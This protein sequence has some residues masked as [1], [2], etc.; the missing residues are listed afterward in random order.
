MLIRLSFSA[1]NAIIKSDNEFLLKPGKY[2]RITVEDHG[3]GIPKKHL[4]KIFDPYFTTKTK[5]S[6]LGLSICYSIIKK[7]KG[8][9]NVESKLG[10]GTK[11]I[12]Y[13]PASL[14]KEKLKKREKKQ[15]TKI[16]KGKILVMDDELT[17]RKSSVRLLT[18]NGFKVTCATEGNQAIKLFKTARD[19]KEPFD[20]VIMDLT[21][22]GG[23]GGKEAAKRILKIDSK[24]KIIVSSGYSD[25]PVMAHYKKYG[26]SGA[27]AKPYSMEEL[28]ASI[29]SVL[30]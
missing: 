25:N 27:L 29:N 7:H 18:Q 19:L 5:G 11:F 22:P 23:M 2:I 21:V 17:V 15:W 3:K 30:G 4:L 9:I 24:A 8:S 28:N 16:N 26:F 1:V 10:K 6:G 14:K 20:L 13:L 12:I